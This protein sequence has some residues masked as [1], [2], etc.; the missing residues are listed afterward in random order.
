MF[1]EFIRDHSTEIVKAFVGAGLVTRL[2]EVDTFLSTV[3][4][5]EDTVIA[6]AI[7]ENSIALFLNIIGSDNAV[8]LVGDASYVLGAIIRFSLI[9]TKQQTDRVTFRECILSIDRLVDVFS[10]EVIDNESASA[11]SQ[12]FGAAAMQSDEGL[13]DKYRAKIDDYSDKI[14][15]LLEGALGL[16]SLIN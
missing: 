16:K 12:A 4:G 13:L 15:V 8:E 6:D 1:P 7:K 11:F 10:Q 5:P 9:S 3:S 14:K 2:G